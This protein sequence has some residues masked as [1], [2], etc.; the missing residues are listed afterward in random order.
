MR[1]EI[2]EDGE[3]NLDSEE[4]LLIQP[5]ELPQQSTVLDEVEGDLIPFRGFFS[6]L[7]DT[8]WSLFRHGP[9][10]PMVCASFNVLS[11]FSRVATLECRPRR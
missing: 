1:S 11:L 10:L 9:E 2:T 5:S 8:F 6:S 7:V 3:C 4:H